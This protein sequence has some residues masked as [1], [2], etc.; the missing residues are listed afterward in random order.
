[1]LGSLYG[2][3]RDQEPPQQQQQERA[4]KEQQPQQPKRAAS[5]MEARLRGHGE[6][7]FSWMRFCATARFYG[8]SAAR[9]RYTRPLKCKVFARL[10]TTLRDG[11]PLGLSFF[12][13]ARLGSTLKAFALFQLL[14]W[15]RLLI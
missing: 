4:E 12:A 15:L 7:G 1:M 2:S 11:V 13:S 9:D 10:L 14:L 8:S 3:I 6:I 5:S